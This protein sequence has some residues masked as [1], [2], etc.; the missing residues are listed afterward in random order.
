MQKIIL[1]SFFMISGFLS[2]SQDH[3]ASQDKNAV[4][5]DAKGF[6][7]IE[8]SGGMELYLSPGN[9]ESVAISTSD[10]SV[11]DHIRAD[12]ENGVLKIYLDN[13]DG[14]WNTNKKMTAYVSFKQLDAIEASGGSN[15]FVQD[16]LKGDRLDV[17][18]SGGGHL[19]GKMDVSD[20]S[21]NQSGGSN[22]YIT[23]M[24]KDLNIESSGGSN[25]KGYDL[26]TDIGHFSASG[27][28]EIHVTVNKEFSAI[29]SGGSG[30]YYKGAGVVKSVST[31]GGS[32]IHKEG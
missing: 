10:I 14:R 9:E 22:V 19:R 11:R 12:V 2:F 24:V 31:S 21:I 3:T 6:H 15:V 20:L 4:T 8:V 13:R 23:G 18:L 30:V 25:F 7:A 5:R 16:I 29:A 26:V 28:G 1:L 17:R 32:G 27:G